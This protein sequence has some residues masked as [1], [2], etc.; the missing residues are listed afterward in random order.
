MSSTTHTLVSNLQE[1]IKMRNI[2][3]VRLFKS[4]R[5]MAELKPDQC[6]FQNG[7]IKTGAVQMDVHSL[8]GYNIEVP[9]M[10]LYF[11]N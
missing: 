7:F 10:S 3:L 5:L 2:T 4:G 9:S 6:I 1:L 11:N 8:I